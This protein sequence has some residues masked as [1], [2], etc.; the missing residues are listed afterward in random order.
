MFDA[1]DKK[2]LDSLS[3]I[4]FHSPGGSLGEGI[5]M[6]R[7]IRKLNLNTFASARLRAWDGP[8]GRESVL[9][10]KMYCMSACAYAFAGG[11]NRH[12]ELGSAIGVHQFASATPTRNSESTAQVTTTLLRSYLRDMGVHPD[13]VDIASLMAPSEM[14]ILSATEVK[15]LRLDN[16]TR[17]TSGWSIHAMDNGTPLLK[18]TSEMSVGQEVTF[19]LYR[20]GSYFLLYLSIIHSMSPQLLALFPVG[21]HPNVEIWVDNKLIEAA[22]DTAWERMAGVAGGFSATVRLDMAA[23]EAIARG[24][25]VT[26]SDNVGGRALAGIVPYNVP[27]S[28]KGLAE[29][30]RLLRRTN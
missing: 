11:V 18:H 5:L 9:V 3:G 4:T 8:G 27:L 14:H 15:R 21:T 26:L 23:L 30:V 29:G 25:K 6:G 20:E 16:T 13:L 28:T 2:A 22:E 7:E 10:E 24:R 19:G 17:H 1:W 12:V